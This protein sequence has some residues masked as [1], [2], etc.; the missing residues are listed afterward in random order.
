[1]KKVLLVEPIHQSGINI[2]EAAGLE[3]LVS[4]STDTETLSG[5]VSGGDVFGMIVRTSKLEGKVLEAGKALRIIG[6]HG[7]GYNNIDLNAA[8]KLNIVISNV[9]DANAYSVAEYVI[10]TVLLLSRKLIQGDGALRAGKM[11]QPGA[12]LP[13]L[14]KKFNL[15]GNELP[16]RTLGIVGLG[17]IGIHVANMAGVLLGMNILGYDPY[18]KAPNLAFEKVDDVREVFRRADFVTLHTP[19]TSET[20]NMVNADMLNL[21]KP[22]AYLINA[23]RGELIDEKALS[24][25][26]A[27]G[28][29][30]GAVLDVF[31]EE[32]PSLSNPLFAAPNLLLTPHVAGATDEAVERLSIGAAQAV[33][34]LF[35]GKKP[36]NIVNPHV[37]DR[38]INK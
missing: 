32:P 6:R 37:W 1:M 23:A 31:R 26:L 14:V 11:A 12:S 16:K 38:I 7:I 4:P 27:A 35:L 30:A 29:I 34:D 15:G 3:V 21:M 17:K 18:Q 8:D 36:A 2:L 33:A 28:K 25:A 19:A 13:G 9:P 10:A 5:L 24:D 22:G 20:E